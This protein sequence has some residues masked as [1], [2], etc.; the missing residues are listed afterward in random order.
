MMIRIKDCYINTD[1]IEYISDVFIASITATN[2]IFQFHV[3]LKNRQKEIIFGWDVKTFN[4][5]TADTLRSKVNN[6][7]NKLA[8]YID[9]HTIISLD[10]IIDLKKQNEKRTKK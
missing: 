4:G 2:R 9:E 3:Y 1:T 7:R 6:I 10:N 8:S 5:E